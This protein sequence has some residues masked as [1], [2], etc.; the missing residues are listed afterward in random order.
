[1]S[2]VYARIVWKEA[3]PRDDFVLEAVVLCAQVEPGFVYATPVLLILGCSETY[4]DWV[5]DGPDH[6][7]EEYG[8]KISIL[9]PL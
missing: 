7:E 3:D 5:L 2:H 9:C 4:E 8:W 6:Y 1:M